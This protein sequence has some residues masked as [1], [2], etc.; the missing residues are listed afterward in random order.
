[1]QLF[2]KVEAISDYILQILLKIFIYMHEKKNI[3]R[4]KELYTNV[5]LTREQEKEIDDLWVK[6]YGRKYSKKWHRLYQSYLGVYDVNY[7]PEILFSTK[8]QPL[9]NPR[10]IVRTITDKALTEILLGNNGVR[11]PKTFLI[12]ANEYF[13]DST[14]NVIN[15][16]E[17]WSVIQNVGA[18]VIKPTTNTSSGRGVRIVNIKDGIDLETGESVKN[19]LKS[20]KKNY[21]VQE[22]IIAHTS[23]SSLHEASLNTLRVITYILEGKIYCAPLTL[24]IGMNGSIV[25]NSHAGGVAIG[26]LNDGKLKGKAFSENQD[27]YTIHPDSGVVFANHQIARTSEVTEIAKKLHGKLPSLGIVSWDFSVDMEGEIILIEVNLS[28]QSIWFPQYAN[29][30][31]IF[32]DNTEKMI[33]M[34]AGN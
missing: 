31:G 29:G 33:R 28:S 5:R 18:A 21:I 34:I 25:D 12:N 17:A 15:E 23:Y 1:M 13:Y 3:Y 7:F 4:K 20:Y 14:R 6:N 26:V 16:D 10:Y 30:C 19:I 9:L 22:K 24:R 2:Y 32:E 27:S 8:L 11:F